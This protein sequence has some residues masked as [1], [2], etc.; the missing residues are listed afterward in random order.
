MR[1]RAYEFDPAPET[2]I[3]G[4]GPPFTFSATDPESTFECSL[5]GGPFTPCAAPFDPGAGPGT[6]T[7]A[8][9]AVDP[10][11]QAD[12]SAAIVTFTIQPPPTTTPS[13]TATPTPTATPVVNRT[14]VV[15]GARGTVKVKVPGSNRY[16]DLDATI[17]IPV[18]SRWTR[19][20][21]A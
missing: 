18:G 17:G 14:I 5:D 4:A 19:A 15:G 13:P 20:R 10:Q 21:A 7:L 6:H 12:S 1:R 16:V 11:G 3:A 9:R 2:S 8:V